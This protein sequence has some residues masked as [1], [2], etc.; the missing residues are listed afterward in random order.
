MNFFT[1]SDS[2]FWIDV[3]DKGINSTFQLQKTLTYGKHNSQSI[4]SNSS[5]IEACTR[6]T[7]TNPP[8]ARK[9]N[10]VELGISSYK[11]TTSISVASKLELN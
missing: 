1:E 10:F 11:A 3:I 5:Q 4:D 7:E 6:L 8:Y 9:K 2:C